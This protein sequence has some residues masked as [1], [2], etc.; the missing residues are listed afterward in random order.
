MTQNRESYIEIEKANGKRESFNPEKLKNSLKRSGATPQSIERVIFDVESE[1]HDGMTTQE[2][3]TRAFSLL[4]QV[5]R[6]VASRYSLRKAIMDLGP[7]GFAF[8]DFIA[9]VLKTKNF[10]TITRQ[11]A[12]GACVSHEVDVVAW[13]SQKLVMCEAKFHNQ[14]GIKSD[15]KVALYVKARFDDLKG[16][17][18]RYGG[19]VRPLD[20]GWLITN[21]KF[22]ST[23]IHYGVCKGLTMIGWNY[24]E[25]GNLQEMIEEGGLHPITCLTRLSSADKKILMDNQ[26]VLCKQVKDNPNFLESLLGNKIDSQ[27]I[28]AEINEL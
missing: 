6:R 15:V 22:S 7:S 26:I 28:L 25:K 18:F 5:E 14:L 12:L 1:L 17:M 23:A 21:T 20:E 11:V 27:A 24:P 3:Y 4:N 10:E 19:R 13:N 8:E 9:Q 2:I 16:N